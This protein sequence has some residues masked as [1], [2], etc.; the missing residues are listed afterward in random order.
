M[1]VELEAAQAD[2]CGRI[3]AFCAVVLPSLK[4]GIVAVGSFAFISTWNN[5]LFAVMFMSS[6][7]RSPF[8]SDRATSWATSERTSAL[9]PPAA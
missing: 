7:D 2:G 5:V 1:P 4:P 9:S 8:P 6:Q 3:R